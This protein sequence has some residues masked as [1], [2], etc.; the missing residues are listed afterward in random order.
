MSDGTSASHA[1]KPSDERNCRIAMVLV[2]VEFWDEVREYE[3][4][5]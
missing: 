2:D 1:V 5:T 4:R 3:P